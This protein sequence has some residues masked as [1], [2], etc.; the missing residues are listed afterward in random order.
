MDDN[1]RRLTFILGVSEFYPDQT[2]QEEK[3]QNERSRLREGYFH[4]MAKKEEKS[5]QSGNFIENTYALVEDCETGKIHY[6]Q[7][8]LITFIK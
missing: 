2:L 5:A 3:E 7:P 4:G 1:L 8:E 6:V